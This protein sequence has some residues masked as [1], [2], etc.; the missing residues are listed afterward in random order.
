MSDYDDDLAEL[1]ADRIMP[2][3][4]VLSRAAQFMDQAKSG[5]A[6]FG[7]ADEELR[8]AITEHLQFFRDLKEPQ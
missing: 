3:Q 7:E 5:G 2:I 1:F 4:E 8:S 6:I